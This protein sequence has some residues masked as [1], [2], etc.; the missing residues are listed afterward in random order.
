MSSLFASSGISGLDD[1]HVRFWNPIRQKRFLA[2]NEESKYRHFKCS[3]SLLAINTFAVATATMVLTTPPFLLNTCRNGWTFSSKHP[4]FKG[5]PRLCNVILVVWSLV[6]FFSSSSYFALKLLAI[7]SPNF[8]WGWVFLNFL[9][10][11]AGPCT[12]VYSPILNRSSSVNEQFFCF[13]VLDSFS[14]ASRTAL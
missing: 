9:T 8:K 7:L 14:I 2:Q 11:A 3:Y 1:V 10:A 4:S 5:L 13:F 6:Y 12:E